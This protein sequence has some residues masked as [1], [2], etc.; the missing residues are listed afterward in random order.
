MSLK[1]PTK[2]C[3]GVGFNIVSWLKSSEKCQQIRI[4]YIE[5]RLYL[6][7]VLARKGSASLP[8]FGRDMR[9]VPWAAL[10]FRNII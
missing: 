3:Q 6:L 1:A 4:K 7:E 9:R 8:C 10:A 2:D 5:I